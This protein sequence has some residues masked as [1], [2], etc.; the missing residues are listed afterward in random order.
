MHQSSFERSWRTRKH[1]DLLTLRMQ[2]K[3]ITLY[4]VICFYKQEFVHT[5]NLQN[6]ITKLRFFG[7]KKRRE[8]LSNA[9]ARTSVLENWDEGFV[10]FFVE[11]LLHYLKLTI[12]PQTM[13]V[14]RLL[15]IRERLW[16]KGTF[17]SFRERKTK[18]ITEELG[19]PKKH[20]TLP[21]KIHETN[22][23]AAWKLVLGRRFVSF[24]GWH[25]VLVSG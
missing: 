10:V 7:P 19:A 6:D 4:W 18:E 23:F 9:L 3:D 1:K 16:L 5:R 20:I 17:V 8:F 25:S 14:E 15:S 22:V 12:C 11:A 2:Q 13:V 24:L 21:L